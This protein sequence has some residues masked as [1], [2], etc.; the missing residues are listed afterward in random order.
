VD[1]F[2]SIITLRVKLLEVSDPRHSWKFCVK[3]ICK[4]QPCVLYVVSAGG[5]YQ[6]LLVETRGEKS[7]I[8]LIQLNRPKALNALCDSLMEELQQVLDD[9]EKDPKISCAV[10]TG[11]DKAFAGQL[12][13]CSE[14]VSGFN[15]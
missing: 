4:H 7:N 1:S 14:V 6:H 12:G 3:F 5:K 15:F 8:G 9:F 13:V 11:S 2:L 10:I